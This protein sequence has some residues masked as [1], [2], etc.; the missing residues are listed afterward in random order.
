MKTYLVFTTVDVTE[1]TIVLAE[2]EEEAADK[3][4]DGDFESQRQVSAT[5]E[6]IYRIKE[7]SEKYPVFKSR[8]YG[9]TGQ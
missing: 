4:H 8:P 6:E 3:L 1:E 7:V 9:Y 2:N 5:N